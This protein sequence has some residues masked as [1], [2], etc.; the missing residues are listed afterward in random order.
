MNLLKDCNGCAARRAE[1]GIDNP[2]VYWLAWWPLN[3]LRRLLA[4]PLR[5]SQFIGET[6]MRADGHLTARVLRSDGR[7][8]LLDLGRNTI[9]DAAVAFMVDDFVAGGATTDITNMNFHHWGTGACT[10]PPPCTATALVTPG[11]E[12][13][14]SGTKSEPA[15]NQYRTIATITADATKTITEWGLFSASTGGTAWSLRCFTGIALASGDAIEF[16]YTLSISC[17]SG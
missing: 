9:T 1:S 10:T 8:E 3:R 12:A 17:V 4:R 6:M 2:L 15:A 7:V 14:V 5:L 13:R 16:T 11:T